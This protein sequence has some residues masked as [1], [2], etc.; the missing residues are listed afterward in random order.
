MMFQM[1]F[2]IITPALITS[3]FA[4]RFKF[5]ALIV[6]ITGWLLLVYVPIAHWVWA[7]TGFL[8]KAG[9]LDFAGDT[10]VH[11]GDTVVH[12]NAGMATAMR[13][14]FGAFPASLSRSPNALSVGLA[15]RANRAHR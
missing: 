15:R 13:T 3:A 1:T 12:I 9:V 7:S 6:F 2:A 10:V 4:D 11:I 14:T 8:N 5:S